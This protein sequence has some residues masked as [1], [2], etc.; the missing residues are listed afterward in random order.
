[1]SILVNEE[2]S[3]IFG[4]LFMELVVFTFGMVAVVVVDVDCKFLHLFMEMCKSLG[5]KFW[6][7]S[8]GNHKGNS[9]EK[10]HRCLNKTQTIRR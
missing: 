10:Y 9:V 2:T 8:R 6:P 5:F 7:L 4:K 3:E 1:M